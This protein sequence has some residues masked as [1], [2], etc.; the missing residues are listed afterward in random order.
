MKF[1][2][3]N[4]KKYTVF[5]KQYTWD[6]E[7]RTNI[8]GKKV[9]RTRKKKSNYRVSLRRYEN[10]E[11]YSF[12]YNAHPPPSHIQNVHLNCNKCD[13]NSIGSL[14]TYFVFVFWSEFYSVVSPSL[15]FHLFVCVRFANSVSPVSQLPSPF[16]V[17][18][19]SFFFHSIFVFVLAV[20]LFYPGNHVHALCERGTL[21]HDA[22][23]NAFSNSHICI[24]KSIQLERIRIFRLLL[25]E[26]C[27]MCARF[28]FAHSLS[29][30][31]SYSWFSKVKN[32]PLE[33]RCEQW[34]NNIQ[35]QMD[36]DGRRNVRGG[37]ER[38]GRNDNAQNGWMHFALSKFHYQ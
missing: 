4:K 26:N 12:L 5:Y 21:H 6:I 16:S 25:S 36:S 19:N 33:I 23:K 24:R 9:E 29:L 14:C 28:F 27:E 7:L 11:R 15:I 20:V 31:A 18:F 34:I 22:L 3:N 17:W 30:F 13:A 2:R 35:N 37:Q 38:G 10:V 1:E 8:H 32:S